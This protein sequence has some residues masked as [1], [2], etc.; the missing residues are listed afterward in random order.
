M[1]KALLEFCATDSQRRVVEAVIE[2]GSQP[3]AARAL[4]V[5]LRGLER[6]MARV[7][8]VAALRG[9]AP[10]FNQTRPLPPGQELRRISTYYNRD[11]QPTGQWV[12]GAPADLSL[13]ERV[14][15]I[16]AGLADEIKPFPPTPAPKRTR[17]SLLNLYPVAD[18]HLNMFAWAEESG[19]D[20]DLEIAERTLMQFFSAAIK[21]APDAEIG[22]FAQMGDFLHSDS[23]AAVTPTNKHLLDVS[24][25][26]PQAVRAAVRCNRRIVEMLLR[27]HKKVHLIYCDANHDPSAGAWQRETAADAYR[28]EPRVT[29]DTSPD[30][31]YAYQFGKV[32]LGFHHG[33]RRNPNNV[34]VVL[35]A[36]FPK[37]FGECSWRY[38]FTGHL[39][40]DKVVESPLM[41]TEQL[42]SLATSDAYASSAGYVSKR[43]GK[44]ITFH[45]DC[46]EVSR[47]VLTPEMLK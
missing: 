10:E 18:Y 42:R 7:R 2:H 33:H 30:S 14:R 28:N 37:M 3:K 26:F 40:S 43:D 11:G 23:H 34:D 45:R 29:V 1:N 20:W 36:K 35:A 21:Q 41:R 46:G 39:H 15:A 44:V 6:T 47:V 31:Y 9:Y 24:G 13:E 4:G 16:A 12:I 22:L 32:M 8:A 17:E 25:R 27:K 5:N 38:A 19:E